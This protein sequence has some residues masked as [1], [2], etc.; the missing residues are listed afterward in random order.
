MSTRIGI[1]MSTRIGILTGGGDCPQ[2]S[3]GWRRVDVASKQPVA[4]QN[5]DRWRGRSVYARRS[6]VPERACPTR[7]R[8]R[9]AST[10]HD[11]RKRRRSF[12]WCQT[13]C[14]ACRRCTTNASRVST[15]RGAPQLIP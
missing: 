7:R 13:T 1:L 2:A 15:A 6:S 12:G 11:A 5:G 3:L 9:A 10:S 14:I 8:R 4:Q